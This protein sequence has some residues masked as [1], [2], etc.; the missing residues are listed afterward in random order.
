MC[1]DIR[2]LHARNN[3]KNEHQTFTKCVFM[4]L[5][6][7]HVL[8]HTMLN[9]CKYFIEAIGFALKGTIIKSPFYNLSEPLNT[10]ATKYLSAM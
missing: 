3:V 1:S 4:H 6:V 7:V 9:I 10:V 2:P 8:L 5:I